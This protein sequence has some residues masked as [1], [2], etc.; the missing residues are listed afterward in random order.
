ML[1]LI[2]LLYN[3]LNIYIVILFFC[4][5]IIVKIFA[6]RQVRFFEA[7]PGK[8]IKFDKLV[9]EGNQCPVV[10]AAKRQTLGRMLVSQACLSAAMLLMHVSLRPGGQPAEIIC[11]LLGE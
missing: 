5:I 10:L 2:D 7:S 4:K 8:S 6:G 1:F 3:V 9:A 11:C